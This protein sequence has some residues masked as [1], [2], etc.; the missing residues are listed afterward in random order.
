MCISLPE[1]M[2]NAIGMYINIDY[3]IGGYEKAHVKWASCY[4]HISQD[5]KSLTNPSAPRTE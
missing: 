2:G 1:F 5:S 3:F 4:I